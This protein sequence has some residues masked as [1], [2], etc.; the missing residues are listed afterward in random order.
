MRHHCWG[1]SGVILQSEMDMAGVSNAG[2][3]GSIT[4]VGALN[5]DSS[6]VGVGVGSSNGGSIVRDGCGGLAGG[7]WA[8]TGG[9]GDDGVQTFGGTRGGLMGGGRKCGDT[10]LLNFGTRGT[11]PHPSKP[12]L[13]GLSRGSST[14]DGGCWAC[15][16]ENPWMKSEC[17]KG[18]YLVFQGSQ[19]ALVLPDVLPSDNSEISE[20][21]VVLNNGTFGNS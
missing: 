7:G 9:G 5:G 12:G 13:T 20:P 8:Q 17:T 10:R 19:G 18:M 2:D 1:L 3:G 21:R 11:L 15:E 14:S 6:V 16:V 4:D